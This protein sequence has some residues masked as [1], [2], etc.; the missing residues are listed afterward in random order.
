MHDFKE[1]HRFLWEGKD[2]NDAEKSWEKNLAK[3]YYDKL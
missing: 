2:L 3:K 1:H